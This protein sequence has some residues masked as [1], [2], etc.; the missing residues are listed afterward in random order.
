MSNPTQEIWRIFTRPD[1]TSS[2]EPLQLP[3]ERTG[4]N[5]STQML[6]G[7]GCLM[8]RLPRENV[9]KW[10]TAP[11][12]QLGITISGEGIIETGD[13]QKLYLKPGVVT[14]LEDLTGKGHLTHGHGTEDR[15][16]F[17]VGLDDSVKIG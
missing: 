7:P 10:H 14:L 5:W 13:G 17:F 8:K 4:H 2:M 6:A 16:I 11:R 15:L 9:A 1:G 3:L 12:R